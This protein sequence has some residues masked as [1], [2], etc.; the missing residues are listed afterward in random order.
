MIYILKNNKKNIFS[1][2]NQTKYKQ[3]FIICE[4]RKTKTKISDKMSKR[5][6]CVCLLFQIPSG[7]NYKRVVI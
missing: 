2:W 5:I 6:T 1:Y 7:I 3:L 4:I